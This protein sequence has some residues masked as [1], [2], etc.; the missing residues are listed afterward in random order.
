L[1]CS[2]RFSPIW[3]NFTSDSSRHA[4]GCDP[5]KDL[6]QPE[7][8]LHAVTVLVFKTSAARRKMLNTNGV[9]ATDGAAAVN[10]Q[11]L[12]S[13]SY[14]IHSVTLGPST[15]VSNTVTWRAALCLCHD[16]ACCI[17]SEIQIGMVLI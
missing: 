13:A 9:A 7:G 2:S 5:A 14:P 11:W 4:L 16:A 10:W 3:A 17:R 1:Q 8:A 12:V 6:Q 15:V